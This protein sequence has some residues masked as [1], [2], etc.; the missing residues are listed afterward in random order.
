MENGTPRPSDLRLDKAINQLSSLLVP[1]EKLES[2]AIQRRLFALV[3]RRTVVA[4]T[5]GRFI[6]MTRGLFGNFTPEDIRWQDLKDVRIKMGI[7]GA[8]L[9]LTAMQSPD[10]AIAGTGRLLS[11]TGLRKDEAE[12]VYRMCQAQEQAWREKRRIRE[13]EELRA[14]SGG[15]QLGASGGG[16]M[17][18]GAA[19]G[20]GNDA[21]ERLA[22]AK[23]MLEKGLISDSEYESLKARIVSNL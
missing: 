3:H 8:D 17:A 4:A 12:A 21:T 15:I 1:D 20:A 23:S 13:L 11:F 22:Q 5:S 16:S 10:L 14:K 19:A 2:H 18:A 6:G 7:F 9:T